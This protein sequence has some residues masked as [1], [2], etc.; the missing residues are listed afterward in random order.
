ME[1]FRKN[2]FKIMLAMS[3][4]FLSCK[5]EETCVIVTAS[6][7]PVRE[8]NF[9]HDKGDWT[10]MVYM[11]AD[12][13]MEKAALVDINEMEAAEFDFENNH[14]IVLAD[15]NNNRDGY[16]GEWNG[17]RLY[18][19]QHDKNGMNETLVSL[20]LGCKELGLSSRKE[21]ELDMSDP[22]VLKTFVSSTAKYYP[23]SHYAFVM[24][25]ECSGYSGRS[26][27]TRAV[28]FDDTSVSYMENK[29]FADSLKD[30]LEK[31]FDVLAM[32]TC[33]GSEIELLCEFEK[34]ADYFVGM[35]GLQKVEG[36]DYCPLLNLL[37]KEPDEGKKFAELLMESQ[38]EKNISI[39][40]MSKIKDLYS[41]FDLF[42]KSLTNSIKTKSNAEKIKSEI[43][44]SDFCFRAYESAVNPVYVDI[45][46]MAE[47][48]GG[49]SLA[50]CIEKTVRTNNQKYGG[51]GVFL[52]NLDKENNL[53][54]DIPGDY[55]RGNGNCKFVNES[56]HYAFSQDNSGTFLDKI[57]RN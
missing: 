5:M 13:S 28:A 26:K 9:E 19:I 18:E 12:N 30:G 49:Q 14:V 38:K 27:T 47:K 3:L 4:M 35:E 50:S 10:V 51:I 25:G 22:E 33:F 20:R 21:G 45:K 46:Y 34:C 29:D 44:E 23:A 16:D 52:C 6:L 54:L 41:E 53:I 17:T 37:S 1:L 43:L 42:S 32:D 39:V 11:P 56:E 31:N 55:V 8:Y 36:W 2:I 15:C 48:Y 40:D 24:W 57:F 7:E